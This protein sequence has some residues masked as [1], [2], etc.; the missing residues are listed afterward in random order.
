VIKDALDDFKDALDDFKDA[1]GLNPSMPK[2]KAYFCNVINYTKLVILNILPFEED[3]LPVKYLGVPLVSSRLIARDYG[4]TTSMWFDK[5]CV[6][7]PLSNI[8]SSRDIIRA[9]FNHAS[10]VR[11]CIQD[12]LRIWPDDWLVKYPILN[13]IPIPVIS[14]DKSDALE[15]RCSDGMGKPFLVHNVWDSIRP[16]DNPVSWC[17]LVWF[18][19]CISRH[20]F[21]M[22][23]IIKQR[24]RTQDCLRSWEVNY[25]LGVVCPLCETQPDSHEHLF[26]VCPFSQQIWSRVQQNTGLTGAGPSLASII[27]YFLPIAKRKSSKNCID[28]P[29][30]NPTSPNYSPPSLGN[31]F[32]YTLED[33]SEKF[34]SGNDHRGN[35]GSPPIRYK[36]S[37]GCNLMAPKRT[38]TF[39]AP[40]M[41]QAAIRK[42]IAA[43]DATALEAQAANMKN[44][45]NTNRNTEPREAH[46]AK[47]CSYKEFMSYQPFNFKG[48][49]GTVGLIR[50]FERTESVFSR[51][52]RTEDC[53]VKFATGTLTE[54][55]LSWWNLFAQPIGIEEAYKITWSEFKKLL[56]KKYCPRTE[57]KKMEDEFYNMTVKGNDLKTYVR[58]F[59]ELAVLC[60]TMVSNSEKMIKVF[61][62]G[63]P[64]SIKG[65]VTASK[66]QTL[67]EAI[68]NVII[69]YDIYKNHFHG[70]NFVLFH[71]NYVT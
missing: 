8:I 11:D 52:N 48:S 30:Y 71:A 64:Q 6:A 49:K 23:L 56:I 20:A 40:T 65:N 31:T 14:D 61:I 24:L 69:T 13:S 54:E 10:K 53:K 17:D 35:L 16:R 38:S 34:Y 42:L 45:D 3:H 26:F 19:A 36:E 25:D 12:G 39:A 41:T 47:R 9:G 32:S 7:G 63:L 68:F 66:P 67:E 2:S 18:H 44:A 37:S 70:K 59:H 28:I 51:S 4:R 29:N 55:A 15:W 1:S 33:P 22:W 50:W 58:R 60:P 5:W 62:G 46:I 43:S 27:T 21:N 57:I